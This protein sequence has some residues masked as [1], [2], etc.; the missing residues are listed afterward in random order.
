MYWK[1][2]YRYDPIVE[3]KLNRCG[4]LG[5]LRT[6]FM[7][8]HFGIWPFK[9][10]LHSQQPNNL[11]REVVWRGKQIDWEMTPKVY[12]VERYKVGLLGRILEY[13]L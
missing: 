3:E 5:L 2:Q 1:I 6:G 11:S 8:I 9:I 7:P 4:E 12:T 10:V 13:L